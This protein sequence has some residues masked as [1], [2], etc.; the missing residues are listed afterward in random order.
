[1]AILAA[2]LCGLN[3]K[4]IINNLQKIK[5]VNGRLELVKTFNNKSKVYLDYAHTPHALETVIKSLVK[6]YKKDCFSI[7]LW[8][9]KRS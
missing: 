6:K 7:W 8:R 1:M 5:S 9:R 3:L 4:K 2:G